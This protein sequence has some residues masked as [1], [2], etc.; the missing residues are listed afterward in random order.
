MQVQAQSPVLALAT[1][2]V[3]TLDDVRGLRIRSEAGTVWITEEADFKDHIV[4]PGDTRVVQRNGRTVIQ[5]LQ[6]AWI[7]LAANDANER[8]I[9]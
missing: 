9:A 3:V 5:A 7:A 2:E 6:P 8:S 4:G 1:G